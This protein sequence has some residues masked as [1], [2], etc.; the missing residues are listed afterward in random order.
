MG[1][2]VKPGHDGVDKRKAPAD[3]GGGALRYSRYTAGP[4]K[5]VFQANHKAP[6]LQPPRFPC[7]PRNAAPA[8]VGQA[9]RFPRGAPASWLPYLS[10]LAADL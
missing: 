9:F 8:R 1:G 5:T 6:S 4:S 10:V 3:I 7:G 2:R